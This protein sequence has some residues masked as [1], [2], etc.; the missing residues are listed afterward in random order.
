[1]EDLKSLI[2]GI[3]EGDVSNSN[4]DLKFCSSD[5]SLFEVEPKLV[6]FPKNTSDIKKLVNFA[7]ESDGV[8]LTIRAGGTGM[9]GGAL[10]ESVVLDI[11]KYLKK[12]SEIE[13]FNEGSLVKGSI[14]VE[15]GVYYRDFEKKTLEK[16]LLMPSFPASREICA[17]GGMALNNSGGELTLQYGKTE[18]YIRSLK[19]IFSDGNE[20]EV[21]PLSKA[22]LDSKMAQGD[23]EGELYRKTFELISNNDEILKEVKPKVSKNSAGY[24]LWNVWDKKKEVFDLTKLIVGSQGTL[25]IV[26]EIEFKL[27]E[28]LE[29]SQMMIVFLDDLSHLGDITLDVLKHEP[30]TFESYDDKTLKLAT[31]FAFEFIKKLGFRNIFTMIKNGISEAWSILTKGFPKL[32]L[33]IT[34]DG[35]NKLELSQKALNLEKALK[36]YEPRYSEVIRDSS[37]AEEYWLVRRES[38]NLLRYRVKGKKTA[39]FIDDIVVRPEVL[40]AF[41]PEL[42]KILEP[43][44]DDMIYNIAGHIGNGNFHIIPLMDFELTRTKEIIPEIAQKVYDLVI[45]Y[46]GSITGEHNDGIIR[47]PFLEK[48]YGE[49]VNSLFV[50]TKKIFDS[51]NI[52]N[53][54]KKVGGTLEYAVSKVKNHN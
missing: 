36:K 49:K 43:Y 15:P 16:N 11:S 21:R 52:F 4:D 33:Q 34:F 12:I 5:A 20:Y 48:Q 17:V 14:K 18:D 41:L 3:I 13:E 22:E 40:T 44:Q 45:K 38:F 28:K 26:T 54:G 31:R 24:Y 53:P 23:F 27:V 50:D 2:K 42:N 51:K 10:T 37:E 1:M 25:G 46:N 39:P 19:I 35:N 7:S 47:T 6:V 8:S 32:V 29:H 9:D 30:T